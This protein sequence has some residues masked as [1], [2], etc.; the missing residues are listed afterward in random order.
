[1]RRHTQHPT[2][3]SDAVRCQ[4]TEAVRCWMLT[5]PG[6][7]LQ[8]WQL[9]LQLPVKQQA[10]AAQL[11]R[12]LKRQHVLKTVAPAA[13]PATAPSTAAQAGANDCQDGIGGVT[14]QAPHMGCSGKPSICFADCLCHAFP[15]TF[16]RPS[17]S[18]PRLLDPQIVQAVSPMRERLDACLIFPS[19]PAVMKLNKLGTFSMSQLGQ[20][21]SIIS[22]FIKSARQNNDNFEEGLL[23]LVRTLPKVLKFL[24]S[25]KVRGVLEGGVGVG[26]CGKR[27]CSQHT[28]GEAYIL[29]K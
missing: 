14:C 28:H 15:L 13:A 16:P 20:S 26:R 22:D 18:S 1:M 11:R 8:R 12:R 9:E 21:K 17:H 19:M 6:A 29:L 23:K 24:P 2:K 4:R 7:P 25:D 10:E 3:R 27:R 5:P